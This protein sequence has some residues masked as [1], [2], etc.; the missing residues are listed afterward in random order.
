MG[1]FMGQNPRFHGKNHRFLWIFDHPEAFNVG[2]A[3]P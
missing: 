1:K 2:K 3:M